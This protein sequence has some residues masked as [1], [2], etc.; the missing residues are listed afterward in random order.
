[1]TDP[2]PKRRR[3][4]PNKPDGISHRGRA[5]QLP[6][7]LV[8]AAVEAYPDTT[9]AGSVRQALAAGTGATDIRAAAAERDA[10]Q[11]RA[12]VLEAEIHNIR[13]AANA[14]VQTIA[15]LEARHE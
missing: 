14:A 3:G 8:E 4:R 2:T 12:D 7:E 11:R 10:A 9:V 13:R 1:M 6:A 15:A 5:V